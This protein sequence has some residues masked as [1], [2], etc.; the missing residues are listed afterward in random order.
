MGNVLIIGAGSVGRVTAYKCACNSNIFHKIVIASKTK[1]KCDTIASF[2]Q[3]KLGIKVY[4]ASLDAEKIED[5]LFLI[6]TFQIDIVINVALPYQDLFIMEACLHSKVPYIDTANYEPKDE[7]HYQYK[8]QWDYDAKFRKSG[9]MAVLGAGFDPGATNIFTAYAAK[10]YFDEIHCLDIID[11]NAGNHGKVFATNF[12]PEINIREIT[13]KGKFYENGKWH[14]TKPHEIK[15]EI[16]YPEIG[17]RSSYLIF[18]E[19][20][21]SLVKHF[22]TLKRA[23]FWMTFSEEYL[24]YL[25]VITN[26]GMASIEPISYNGVDIVPLQFLKAVLPN[27]GDLAENYTG[28][29][30]IGCKIRGIK[31]EQEKTYFIY[32]N[33]SH[34]EAYKETESQ[35][36]SYTA[37]VPPVI[38]AMLVLQ[39]KWKGKGVFNVEQLEPDFFMQEMSKQGLPWKEEFD[40]PLNMD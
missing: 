35:A 5:T 30:S 19:E 7:A 20:L 23:R 18:H 1:T 9:V 34:T 33:C 10:H 2:I 3:R 8:W 31:D 32:N 40:L 24:N 37:G 21:E 6:H 38:A 16:F 28:F 36:I 4:T 25:R 11:C 39:K 26:I 13:Q 12:N 17:V 22:P 27:P 15:K 29:T 14:F